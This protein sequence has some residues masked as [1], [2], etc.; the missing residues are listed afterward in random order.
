[1]TPRP[2]DTA[3]LEVL[4]ARMVAVT[5]EIS[6]TIGRTAFSPL[7]REGLDYA[8][9]LFDAQGRMLAQGNSPATGHIGS[10]PFVAKSYLAKY[11]AEELE[12]GDVIVTN[13][14]WLGAGHTNDL[15]T[16]TP[17]FLDA[18]MVG[19]VVCSQ[20]LLDIG[21]RIASVHSTEVYEE[22]LQ[23]PIM[24]LASRGRLNE[25]LI[26]LLKANVRMSDKVVGDILAQ[27]AAAEAGAR[28]VGAVMREYHMDDLEWL[29]GEVVDRTDRAMRRAIAAAPD[30]EYRAEV[31][32]DESDDDGRRLRLCVQVTIQ[33]DRITIDFDGTSPQVKQPINTVLNY[34]RAYAVLGAK[35]A[36]HPKLPNNGGTYRAIEVTAPEGSV[37]NCRFPSA[38]HFRHVLGLRLPEL[39]FQALAGALPG[40]IHAPSGGV[41]VWLWTLSGEEPSGGRFLCTSDAF[42]GLGGRDG[43]DGMSSVSFPANVRDLPVEVIEAETP[44]LVERRE[45][46]EDSAGA[47][48]FRGGF[49]EELIFRN[50][51]DAEVRLS[52]F[53][54][55]LTGGAEGLLGG[56]PGSVGRILLNGEP[57][58]E[59]SGQEIT[60]GRG[61]WV[62]LR[63][64]GGGGYGDATERPRAA[65]ER[66]VEDGLVSP[67]AA[68]EAY[69][70][71]PAS[72]SEE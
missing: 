42:G 62:A 18:S 27:V 61:D 21:G 4:W 14:A 69:R 33:G 59:I 25:D 22:G 47:G 24:K 36:F 13:D 17:V 31:E 55:R 65:V 38:V 46:M 10:M 67:R 23:I 30:G 56:Q 26:A 50:V 12:P 48:R 1:M 7:V 44:V 37:L 53:P 34:T 5:N 63:V 11:P 9:G 20:H 52:I 2:V 39:I 72:A 6:A 16:A 68:I 49:G 58:G 35:L 8:V 43:G 32:V 45:L 66:D 71:P 60:L 40:N 19:L 15:Y 64:P 29:T 3:P 41:P 54:G 57:T 28:R 51:R 70:F